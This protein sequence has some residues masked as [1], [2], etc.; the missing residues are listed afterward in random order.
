M[1]TNFYCLT[2]F[3]TIRNKRRNMEDEVCAELHQI[4][5]SSK[6]Y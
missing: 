1:V 2:L 4:L 3:A 5:G 6:S